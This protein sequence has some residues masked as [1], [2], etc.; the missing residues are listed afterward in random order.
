[1]WPWKTHDPSGFTLLE[2]MVAVAILAMALVAALGSQSQ[3]ISLANR[4]KF[5]TTGAFLAQAKM[6]QIEAIAPDELTSDSGDFGDDFPGYN[7]KTEVADSPIL[8]DNEKLARH[9]KQVTLTVFLANTDG[10]EYGFTFY[11]FSP[12]TE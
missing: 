11:R 6:A 7:W 9:V 10:Y 3:G 12:K 4:A 1:M 8:G 2:V 5:S